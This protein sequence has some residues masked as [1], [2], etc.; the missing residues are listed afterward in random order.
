MLVDRMMISHDKG[1]DPYCNINISDSN[2][3]GLNPMFLELLSP[4][5]EMKNSR[6]AIH[7]NLHDVSLS[8]VGKKSKVIQNVLSTNGPGHSI[9]SKNKVKYSHTHGIDKCMNYIIY[10]IIYKYYPYYYFLI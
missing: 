8:M 5:R 4:S 9:N 3:K 10:Y 1:N 2:K 7:D 6:N